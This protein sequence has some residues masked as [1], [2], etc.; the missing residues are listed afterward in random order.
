MS[1]V[2]V[3]RTDLLD[4]NA[5]FT[6][7][8]LALLRRAALMPEVDRIFVDAAI[9]QAACR[10]TSDAPGARGWLRKLRP[11]PGHTDHFH[12]AL[13]C[14]DAGCVAR[15]PVPAGEGCGREL[16]HWFRAEVRFA[17]PE[18]RPRK[19]LKLKD[20]PNACRAVLAAP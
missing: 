14:P 9:K 19:I 11:W 12:V 8:Q 6:P 4:V 5:H 18:A 1:P 16:A 10:D 2:D 17:K 3:V 20:L 13:A 7:A 15:N